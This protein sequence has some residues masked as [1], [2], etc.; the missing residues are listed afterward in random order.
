MTKK[1]LD[2]LL[3]ELF[4]GSNDEDDDTMDFPCQVNDAL[5]VNVN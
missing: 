3:S 1:E 2:E 4:D 5:Y